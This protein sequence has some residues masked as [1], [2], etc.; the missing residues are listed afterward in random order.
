MVKSVSTVI[1]PVPVT[2]LFLDCVIWKGFSNTPVFSVIDAAGAGT[3]LDW[4]SVTIAVN[5]AG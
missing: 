1:T 3:G 4:S 5:D 2:S